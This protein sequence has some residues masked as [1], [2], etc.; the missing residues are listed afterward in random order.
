VHVAP[1]GHACAQVPQL[2]GSLAV[3]THA[4]LQFVWPLGHTSMQVPL[5]QT[6]PAGQVLLQVPQLLG[7]VASVTHAPLHAV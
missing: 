4:P 3:V 7:S 6:C 5:E 2:A 1:A